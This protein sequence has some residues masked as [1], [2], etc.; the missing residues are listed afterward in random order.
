MN[1]PFL[2]VGMS[3]LPCQN[4][5]RQFQKPFLKISI[6]Q[7]KYASKEFLGRTIEIGEKIPIYSGALL[8]QEAEELR[9]IRI[10]Y[11]QN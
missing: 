5:R 2:K 6:F 1:R 3:T 9:R 11:H 8:F 10:F 4:S 7:L